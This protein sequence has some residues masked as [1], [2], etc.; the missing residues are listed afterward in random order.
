MGTEEGLAALLC[1]PVLAFTWCIWKIEHTSSES[2]AVISWD[3]C[4]SSKYINVAVASHQSQQNTSASRSC[5]QGRYLVKAMFMISELFKFPQCNFR[6][7]DWYCFV[8]HHV[9]Y[10]VL[11]ENEIAHTLDAA[12]QMIIS[13]ELCFLAC[14]RASSSAPSFKSEESSS[15]CNICRNFSH[16]ASSLST[17]GQSLILADRIKQIAAVHP[18][19]GASFVQYSN[20]STRYE[21]QHNTSEKNPSP[22]D[23]LGGKAAEI[24]DVTKALREEAMAKV[25]QMRSD[26]LNQY[27][28]DLSK[29]EKRYRAESAQNN[30]ER[31]ENL[32]DY[33]SYIR[34]SFKDEETIDFEERVY[35]Y[36]LIPDPQYFSYFEGPQ[37]L[38]IKEEDGP[39]DPCPPH[40]LSETDLPPT[41]KQFYDL[42]ELFAGRP[43]MNQMKLQKDFETTLHVLISE[44]NAQ[45]DR[46]EYELQ[47][48]RHM[49]FLAAEVQLRKSEDQISSSLNATFD[50]LEDAVLHTAQKIVEDMEE[51]TKSEGW[52]SDTADNR[53]NNGKAANQHN[54]EQESEE[55]QVLVTQMK[56]LLQFSDDD[57]KANMNLRSRAREVS[58][59]SK[60]KAKPAATLGATEKIALTLPKTRSNIET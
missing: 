57:D 1:S 9:V 11:I 55:Q 16:W 56:L 31:T 52:R 34:Y 23:Y 37:E 14:K 32:A 41:P 33:F 5:G 54:D 45:H 18:G 36:E 21:R 53:N 27:N 30:R 26:A 35:G 40:G 29:A 39:L 49:A 8:D 28:T 44:T 4:L 7:K 13:L 10:S 43:P 15:T 25:R 12:R 48:Q 42:N 51:S 38:E 2:F 59:R 20:N 3:C 46:T 6:E 50:A 17:S 19:T 24:H 58:G 47:Q 22:A 60:Q